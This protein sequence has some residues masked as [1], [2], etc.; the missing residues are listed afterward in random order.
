[1]KK[2]VALVLS[3]LFA[4]VTSLYAITIDFSDTNWAIDGTDIIVHFNANGTYSMTNS[5]TTGTYSS[6]GDVITLNQAGCGSGQ[7]NVVGT[8]NHIALTLITD[9]C[10]ERIPLM[11]QYGQMTRQ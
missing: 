4:A 9:S 6:S 7:Y 1:M 10:A 11:A 5:G 2:Y 8:T 3:L